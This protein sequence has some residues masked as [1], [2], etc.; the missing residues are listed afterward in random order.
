MENPILDYRL[1]S[2]L[3]SERV[4]SIS[5]QGVGTIAMIHPETELVWPHNRMKGL[6]SAET[7]TGMQLQYPEGVTLYQQPALCNL[8]DTAPRI[9]EELY[10]PAPIVQAW[11]RQI[12]IVSAAGLV[13]E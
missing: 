8:A 9:D 11:H 4:A 1:Q 10:L 6:L 12:L 13:P 2:H 5:I 3:S 7:S